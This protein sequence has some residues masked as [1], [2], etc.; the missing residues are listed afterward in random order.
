MSSKAAA[1]VW[2]PGFGH[3]Q[4]SMRKAPRMSADASNRL[5]NLAESAASHAPPRSAFRSSSWGHRPPHRARGGA[6]SRARDLSCAGGPVHRPRSNATVQA[7]QRL[8]ERALEIEPHSSRRRLASR[9]ASCTM[10]GHYAAGGGAPSAGQRARRTAARRSIG[11]STPVA[12]AVGG[13]G[14]SQVRP[15]IESR[16][17]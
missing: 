6:R 12:R 11:R 14:F 10:L 5:A 9:C 1:S 16:S 2:R 15:M 3:T 7:T 4:R 8:S 17:V 13:W